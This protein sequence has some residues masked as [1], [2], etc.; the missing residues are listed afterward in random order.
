MNNS[1]YLRIGTVF[2]WLFAISLFIS[3]VCLICACVS[4]YLSGDKPFSRE[5]VAAA[6]SPI[7]IPIYISLALVFI[8]LI[9]SF[10]LPIEKDKP[11]VDKK[12][13]MM[14]KRFA[15][16]RDLHSADSETIAVVAKE[17]KKRTVLTI[18]VI[19]ICVIC[20]VPFLV[21][22]LNSSNFHKSEINASMI[23][24][25]YVLAP[26]YLI[27]VIYAIISAYISR[28][29]R[30]KEIDALKNLP[31]TGGNSAENTAKKLKIKNIIAIVIVL[32]AI[33]FI[34][35][36]ANLGGTADV[37]T[38]AVNICTECIGLG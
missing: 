5:A 12:S 32:V 29:S 30:A 17:R 11:S 27:S 18:T 35:I 3:S 4:I 8:N 22:A 37:L 19:A 23:S 25:M 1:K 2:K 26:C 15:A 34:V 20:A 9:I 13:E 36:G 10:I 24:A 28:A 31:K 16:S 38:K 14:L 6:F 21:F 7:S 33:T